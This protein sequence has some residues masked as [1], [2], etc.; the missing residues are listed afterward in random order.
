MTSATPL[1]VVLGAGQI[2]THVARLLQ[3]R[4]L[5][6]RLVRRGAF[7]DPPAG[8]ETRSADVGDPAAATEAIAGASVVYH[9]VNPAYWTWATELPRM[10]EGIL[11]GAA[12]AQARLVVLDN[13]YM[14][15]DTSRITE[16]TPIAPVSRKGELRAAAGERLLAAN[17]AGDVR[18]S[19][20]R[21]SDFF[22]P[23]AVDAHIGDRLFRRLFAGKAAECI[24]DPDQIHSY[25]F[26]PD[27]AAA[28]VT[29]GL[30]ARAD[31]CV[32]MLPTPPALSTRAVVTRL[33]AELGVKA[34][35]VALPGWV[36]AMVGALSKPMRELRE[37]RYQWQQPFVIDDSR[38]LEVF[39]GSATSWNQA[40]SE[41][42]SWARQ[43]YAPTKN[44]GNREV[45]AVST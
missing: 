7:T 10:T 25:S 39:G 44:S 13:L 43:R 9:C 35:M 27:V 1:H 29:L 33:G 17:R 34:R 38:F 5:A 28:L 32:W 12:R 11:T 31:G 4:G 18:V 16:D 6:V 37:M 21:A 42:A 41:T 15:G 26:T 45:T 3:A 24:G 40:I 20:G 30:D 2:G 22:G 23:G 8:I 36:I 14:Y 19:I